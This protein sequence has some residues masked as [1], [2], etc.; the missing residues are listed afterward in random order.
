M[1]VKRSLSDWMMLFGLV[2][3]WGSS[4]SLNKIALQSMAPLTMVAGRLL[5]AAIVLLAVNAWQGHSL[6]LPWRRWG[7]FAILAVVGDCVP[8][9]LISWGQLSVDSALAGILMAVIPLLTLL[10]AHLAHQT[11]RITLYKFFGFVIGFGGIVLLVGPEA[12]RNLGGAAFLAQLAILGGAA[13]YAINVV[14]T[15]FNRVRN[16]MITTTGTLLIA[17]VLMLP[18]AVLHHP[19]A[20]LNLTIESVLVVIVLGVFGTALPTLIFF[21]LV[22]SAG[23]TFYAL[24]NYMIPVWAV[25]IGALFLHERPEWNAYVA[26]ALILSG[27]GISQIVR[28]SDK[29]RPL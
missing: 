26:L 15:P 3:M 13:C 1:P 28:V 25:F 23:P 21:R 7:F 22:A 12:L 9:F 24:I 20:S 8:F 5:V 6:W 29:D 11:E 4:F 27:V 19:P 17:A 14:I 18:L 2:V 10:L 16:T